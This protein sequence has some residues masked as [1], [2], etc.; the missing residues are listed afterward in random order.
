MPTSDEI[1]EGDL[2]WTNEVLE[3]K[4]GGPAGCAEW[5]EARI[6]QNL[7]ELRQAPPAKFRA[8]GQPA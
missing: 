2:G 1:L 5:P 7:A 3:M 8:R 4:V 6:W